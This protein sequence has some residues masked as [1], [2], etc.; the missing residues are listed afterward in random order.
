M[1]CNWNFSEIVFLPKV[2]R[3]YFFVEIFMY[4]IRHFFFGGGAESNFYIQSAGICTLFVSLDESIVRWF[5]VR[6]KY[7]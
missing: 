3:S 2:Q 6:K 5:I 4:T 7:C 1:V